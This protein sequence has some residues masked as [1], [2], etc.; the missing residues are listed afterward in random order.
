MTTGLGNRTGIRNA[1][2]ERP[3]DESRRRESEDGRNDRNLLELLQELRTASTGVPVLFGFLLALPFSARFAHLDLNQRHLYI[4]VILT[5]AL[6]A[7]PVSAP[8]AYHRL[9]L[10]HHRKARFLQVANMLALTK[11]ATIATSIC[12]AALLVSSS[13]ANGPAGP[14]VSLTAASMFVGFWLVLPLSGRRQS[15]N[16]EGPEKHR[17]GTRP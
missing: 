4:A 1:T 13:V 10:R 14:A 7:A 11:L 9:N 3:R 2:F 16:M 12:G 15:A 6:A 8:V 17:P 5:A